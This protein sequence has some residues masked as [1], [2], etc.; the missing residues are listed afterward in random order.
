MSYLTFAA[1]TAAAELAGPERHWLLHLAHGPAIAAW[2]LDQS[3]GLDHLARIIELVPEVPDG[4]YGANYLHTYLRQ[5]KDEHRAAIA[6]GGIGGVDAYGRLVSSL[7]ARLGSAGSLTFRIA[8]RELACADVN[9][10]T[11]LAAGADPIR[12]A[13]KLA[14]WEHCYIE[15]ADRAWVAD[16][17]DNGR[18][19]GMYRPDMGW[20]AVANLLRACDDEPVVT[21]HSTESGWPNMWITPLAAAV[22]ATVTYGSMSD[23]ERE[24]ADEAQTRAEE[25]WDAMTPDERWEVSLASLKQRR[26]WSRLAPETLGEIWFGTTVT[27]YDLLAEDREARVA[28]KV[29]SAA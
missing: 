16:I 6:N 29:L 26:P 1:P 2:D 13:A 28:T 15:G 8:G 20:E 27:V 10:N 21:S 11:A 23:E 14:A 3:F 22:P 5:A 24:A 18:E 9:L 25:R 19:I 17:I 7:K 4:Q 12:L